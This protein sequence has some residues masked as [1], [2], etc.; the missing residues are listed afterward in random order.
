M[1]KDKLLTTEQIIWLIENCDIAICPND[2]CPLSAE[3]L[4]YY[5]GDHS[6]L[7]KEN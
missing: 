6:E 4:F 2:E 1:I 7:V 5:T 3:C